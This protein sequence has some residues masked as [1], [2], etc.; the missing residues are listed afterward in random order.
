[1]AQ[2]CFL[3][4]YKEENVK[5]DNFQEQVSH[6]LATDHELISFSFGMQVHVYGE[7]KIIYVNLI[8]ISLV[9]IDTE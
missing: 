1:M 2:S 9:N 7:H 4:Q 5:I 8:E 6:N 3:K